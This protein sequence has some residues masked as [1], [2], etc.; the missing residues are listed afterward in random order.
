[1]AYILVWLIAVLVFF[2]LYLCRKLR[3]ELH[4]FQLNSYRNERYGRWFGEQKGR[5]LKARDFLPLILVGLWLFKLSLVGF[6][7]AALAIYILLFF[8]YKAPKQKKPLVMTKRA[9][10]LYLLSVVILVVFTAFSG[11][12]LIY[13]GY[14]WPL[15]IGFF[16]LGLFPCIL[17]LAANTVLIPVEKSINNSFLREARQIIADMPFLTTIGIT[18]SYGKTSCKFILGQI[19]SEEFMTLVTPASYNTPMGVTRVIRE[20]LRSTHE[21]F[22]AE[23]GAKQKGDVAELC[24]LVQPKLGIITAIGPQ[25]LETFGNLENIINTKFELVDALPPDGLAVLNFDD[26]N[27]RN[28]A[29]A[30]SCRLVSYGLSDKWDY[31]AH[32]IAYNIKGSS[33]VIHAPGGQE[34][35]FTTLLLGRHNICN[36]VAAV[37]AAHELGLPLDKAAKAVRHLPPIEHR[38]QFL[39]NPR[40]YNVID[41][42][43]NSNPQGAAAALEVLASFAG[44]QKIIVTPGMVELGSEEYELNKAFARQAAAVCDYI[45][46]VGKKHSQPLQD[47]LAE[48]AFPPE[49]YYV[50]SDLADA[51]SQLAKIAKPG[52]VVLFENDLPDT[53]NE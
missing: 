27:I 39:A 3:Y 2:V 17:M 12:V 35:Q 32:E 20:S 15:L 23:M 25:H 37:A 45:I 43:F 7:V 52:D 6:G 31:Y 49:R 38:L 8:T 19:L 9:Q 11:L 42:A 44:G 34:Q 36:I 10:R 40:G 33:F 5:A 48:S 4:M 53:Y 21:M 30:Y 24:R 50:A 26:E 22:V 14:M 18:G 51:S 41:D 46:L 47:G 1:M 28:K 13:E 16:I 29:A